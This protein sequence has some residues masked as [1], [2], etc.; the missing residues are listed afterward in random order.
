[1]GSPKYGMLG[2]R[3]HGLD[4]T[5]HGAAEGGFESTNKF[6]D[7]GSFTLLG[8]GHNAFY[9]EAKGVLLA[10]DLAPSYQL[11][12]QNIAVAPALVMNGERGGGA[13]A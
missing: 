10:V 6:R 3:I 8:W 4:G 12:E 9:L 7:T 13:S 11:A 1:M 2:H 5:D